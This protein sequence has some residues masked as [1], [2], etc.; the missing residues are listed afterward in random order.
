MVSKHDKLQADHKKLEDDYAFLQA[1]LKQS[2]ALLQEA[3]DGRQKANSNSKLRPNQPGCNYLVPLAYEVEHKPV[4]KPKHSPKPNLILE[5]SI[6]RA[7][8]ECLFLNRN[9]DSKAISMMDSEKMSRRL[10]EG[11]LEEA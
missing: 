8:Q 4:H 9:P 2:Q 1:K 6:E 7:Q 11:K 3:Q 5:I 10:A